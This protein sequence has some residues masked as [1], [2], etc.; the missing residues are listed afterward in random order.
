MAAVL[1]SRPI[2][3]A[4]MAK[5]SSRQWVWAVIQP[6]G[7]GSIRAMSWLFC[8]VSAVTTVSA[9]QPAAAAASASAWM[10]APPVGS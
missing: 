7:T 5:S 9:W 2:L 10:P 8:T 4:L 1:P 3:M 6:A